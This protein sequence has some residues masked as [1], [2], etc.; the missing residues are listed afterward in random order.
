MKKN[1]FSPWMEIPLNIRIIIAWTLFL[2]LTSIVSRIHTDEHNRLV[3]WL[4]ILWN[5][6]IIIGLY[7][8]MRIAGVLSILIGVL[9]AVI[10]LSLV[11]INIAYNSGWMALT[12]ALFFIVQAVLY[13]YPIIRNWKLLK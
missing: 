8:M 7:K 12:T 6:G 9:S 1:V 13:V 10:G 4:L 11:A 3:F 5:T 2:V